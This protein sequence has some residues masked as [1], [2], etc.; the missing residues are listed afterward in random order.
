M[1]HSQSVLP[2][3]IEHPACLPAMVWSDMTGDA[4]DRITAALTQP[5]P[6]TDLDSTS[7]RTVTIR[8]LHPQ[9]MGLTSPDVE[10][11]S[12][13]VE[14]QGPDPATAS[15][16]SVVTDGY[17][18]ASTSNELLQSHHR[19]CCS[20]HLLHGQRISRS[21][22]WTADAFDQ[23]YPEG[24]AINLHHE[25]PRASF[26]KPDLLRTFRGRKS[27]SL[28]GTQMALITGFRDGANSDG[29]E[30]A[31]RAFRLLQRFKASDQ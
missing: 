1:G 21:E 23:G 4:H 2:G 11:R 12:V 19:Q 30:A 6:M 5:L 22:P 16:F 24:Y 7:K 27:T 26:L 28:I 8:N 10:S 18:L 20:H 29:P 25:T 14:L 15:V 3:W 17:S 9:A 31:M 13:D